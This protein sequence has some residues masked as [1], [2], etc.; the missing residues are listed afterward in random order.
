MVK[1]AV[2]FANGELI[3]G[4]RIKSCINP[5]DF[6]IAAD[7]GHFHI[8]SL[9]LQP[10]LIIGDL[11]SLPAE[12]RQALL[13]SHVQ[14]KSFPVE[15]NETDLELALAEAARL[16]FT[17]ILVVAA[18]G[19]RLDQTLGNLALLNAPFLV[20]CNVCMDDGS[21]RVWL[22]THQRYPHGLQIDGR[23]GE[24]ISLIALQTTAKGIFT[25][26]LKFPLVHEDLKQ[27]E[28]RGISNE[29]LGKTSQ[30]QIE[31]GTLLVIHSRNQMVKKEKETS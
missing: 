20:N 29:L 13:D 21:T 6:I 14:I 25:K 10:D 12:E 24:R 11:D 27:Y 8:K 2:I 19:G 30:I 23:P 26:D 18:L 1:K 4:E 31:E 22:L 9:G 16:G 15:K 5:G 28:T 3:D 17:E 7:G